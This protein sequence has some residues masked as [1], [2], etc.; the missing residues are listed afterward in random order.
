MHQPYRHGVSS[1]CPATTLALDALDRLRISGGSSR[2]LKNLRSLNPGARRIPEILIKGQSDLECT[3]LCPPSSRSRDSFAIGRLP[4]TQSL[5]Q[6]HERRGG[7]L[8]SAH[9]AAACS[10]GSHLG[11]GFSV[12]WLGNL[13]GHSGVRPSFAATTAT[14]TQLAAHGPMHQGTL[15]MTP[16]PCRR[17]QPE[18]FGF[19]LKLWVRGKAQV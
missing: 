11:T 8:G 7:P 12:L 14:D 16:M 13:L 18:W 6:P 5:C 3:V 15:L 19:G 17:D 9:G 10:P 4:A 2:V 1:P